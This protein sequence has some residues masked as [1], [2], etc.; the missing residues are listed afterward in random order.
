MPMGAGIAGIATRMFGP[1]PVLGYLETMMSKRER[2]S[3][4]QATHVAVEEKSWDAPIG[5]DPAD[6]QTVGP[7]GSSPPVCPV[8]RKSAAAAR[9]K[10]S[11]Q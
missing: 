6:D 11:P 7:N 10:A 4:L 1:H 2:V 9:S 8:E 3:G 5:L